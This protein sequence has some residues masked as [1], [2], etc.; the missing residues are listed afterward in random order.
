[1]VHELGLPVGGFLIHFL[2]PLVQVV[3]VV[4]KELLLFMI[5]VSLIDVWPPPQVAVSRIALLELLGFLI[6][7][8]A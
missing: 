8:L 5:M 3:L 7:V 4:L 2:V 1:M 6:L